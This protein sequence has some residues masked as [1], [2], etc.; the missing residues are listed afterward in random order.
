M[1]LI[2]LLHA[3][4]KKVYVSLDHLKVVLKIQGPNSKDKKVI[5]LLSPFETDR[6]TLWLIEEIYTILGRLPLENKG[7]KSRD[8]KDIYFF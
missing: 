5:H 3:I 2:E 8:K 1:W 6:Q 4:K 7:P